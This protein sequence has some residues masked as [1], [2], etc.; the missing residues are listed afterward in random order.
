M[1]VVLANKVLSRRP[2]STSSGRS[3]AAT[4]RL[5]SCPSSDLRMLWPNSATRRSL[6]LIVYAVPSTQTW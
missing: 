3:L 2:T 1:R 4:A 5:I 6:C